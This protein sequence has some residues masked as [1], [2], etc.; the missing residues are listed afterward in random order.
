MTSMI[1]HT[2]FIII[3][4]NGTVNELL[5]IGNISTARTARGKIAAPRMV[6]VRPS[7]QLSTPCARNGF[8]LAAQ[9]N[10]SPMNSLDGSTE[11]N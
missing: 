2:F 10:C 8:L 7:V 4:K 11:P 1:A 6:E 3:I 9:H 5:L